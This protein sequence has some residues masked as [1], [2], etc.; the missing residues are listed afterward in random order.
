[1]KFNV[2]GLTAQQVEESRELHGNNELSQV[3]TETYVTVFLT[4]RPLAF[5]F[6]L[7][8]HLTCFRS[9]WEKLKDNLDDPLVKILCVALVVCGSKDDS[10]KAR[11]RG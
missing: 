5:F 6:V 1:M 11:K 8:H 3:E 9:F 7:C 4:P 10:R 2:S